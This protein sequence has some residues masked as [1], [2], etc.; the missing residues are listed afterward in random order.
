VDDP[1]P[2]PGHDQAQR[3]VFQA[4]ARSLNLA[5]SGARPAEGSGL[6]SE[7]AASPL[8]EWLGRA[9]NRMPHGVTASI[10]RSFSAHVLR[11]P[12]D[13]ENLGLAALGMAWSRQS[14]LFAQEFARGFF[15]CSQASAI[16]SIASLF[17]CQGAL[18]P[19]FELL[20]SNPSRDA[21]MA[22]AHANPCFFA[23]LAKAGAAPS[24]SVAQS[25]LALIFPTPHN[26]PQT[27]SRG[28]RAKAHPRWSAGG[29]SG[30]EQTRD[31]AAALFGHAWPLRASWPWIWAD[32]AAQTLSA[33]K[34]SRVAQ[35]VVEAAAN[36]E[37]PGPPAQQGKLGHFQPWLSA[38]EAIG[39]NDAILLRGHIR[40]IQRMGADPW[41]RLPIASE[42]PNRPQAAVSISMP[43]SAAALAQGARIPTARVIAPT[44]ALGALATGNRSIFLLLRELGAP[45]PTPAC[46]YRWR[47]IFFKPPVMDSSHAFIASP[48]LPSHAIQAWMDQTWAANGALWESIALRRSL[49]QGRQSRHAAPPISDAKTSPKAIKRL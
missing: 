12:P 47:Q 8:R 29:A 19:L 42:H 35:R 23:F 48:G 44:L 37:L 17:E 21:L 33:G 36:G 31:A 3:A 13:S 39:K 11:F 5:L 43:V 46:F 45:L 34:H 28:F 25:A 22:E 15:L 1:L 49:S 38:L 2:A 7:I 10:A 32:Y 41:R 40:R 16:H 26:P 18:A 4:L 24:P 14:P 9:L 30:A 27:P 20:R 6:F